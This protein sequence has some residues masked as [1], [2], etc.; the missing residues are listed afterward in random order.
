MNTAAAKLTAKIE[1]QTTA[2]LKDMAAKLY[3]DMRDG[4]D[5]VFSAV[6]D[7]L[8]IRL[9]EEQFVAFCEKLEG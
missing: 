8:M 4:A 9:P 2:S 1:A 3:G 6:L 7:V 5:M